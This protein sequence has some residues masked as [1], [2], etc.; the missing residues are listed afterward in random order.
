MLNSETKRSFG[1]ILINMEGKQ[2]NNRKRFSYLCSL[3][4]LGVS[5][6]P[7]LY[8]PNFTIIKLRS[9]LCCYDHLQ[10]EEE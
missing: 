8:L 7:V 5:I 10:G 2:W 4:I 9:V 3:D 1:E 6:F